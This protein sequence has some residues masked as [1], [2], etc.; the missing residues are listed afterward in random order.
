LYRRPYSAGVLHSVSDQ[1]Q[2]LQ[3]CI[4]MHHPE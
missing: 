4:T 1:I 3:N 2:S